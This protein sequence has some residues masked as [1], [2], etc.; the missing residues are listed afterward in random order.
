VP[1]GDPARLGAAIRAALDDP[2]AAAARAQRAYRRFLERFTIDRVVDQM[3]A[4]YERA[5]GR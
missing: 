1:A 2:A 4:F 3:R 5:L